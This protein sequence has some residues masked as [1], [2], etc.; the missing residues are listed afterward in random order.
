[1]KATKKKPS[2]R[3]KPKPGGKPVRGYYNERLANGARMFEVYPDGR[4]VEVMQD[5]IDHQLVEAA[6]NLPRGD[7]L[8][9]QL[10]YAV[11]LFLTRWF[12]DH[13]IVRRKAG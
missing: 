8:S 11:S 6:M 5:Q 2:V 4:R 7:R 1:M 3:R 9:P 13:G 12:E 10:V